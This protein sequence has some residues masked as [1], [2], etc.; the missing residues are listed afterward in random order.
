MNN[1][2][3]KINKDTIDAARRGDTEAVM[4]GLSDADRQKVQEVLADKDKLK[5]ILSS[6]AAQ[7]LIKFLGSD[8]QNG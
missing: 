3:D 6:D 4:Q 1:D 8:K 7:K 5:Q 2:F